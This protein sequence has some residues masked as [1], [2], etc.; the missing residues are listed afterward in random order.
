MK[1]VSSQSLTGI[2]LRDAAQTGLEPAGSGSH[3][4]PRNPAYRFVGCKTPTV[5][6]PFNKQRVLFSA[7]LPGLEDI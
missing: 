6:F 2:P 5:C 4:M 7:W 3:R 1:P